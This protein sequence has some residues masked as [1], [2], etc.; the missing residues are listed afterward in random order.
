M[1]KLVLW[2][3]GERFFQRRFS[4]LQL[5]D[6]KID[7]AEIGKRIKVIGHLRQDF[8]IL[9]FG[10]PIFA[11]AKAFFCGASDALQII[12]HVRFSLISWLGIVGVSHW[13]WH[14]VVRRRFL[15]WTGSPDFGRLC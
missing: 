13:L 5:A 8:L 2:R 15:C 12:R 9:L 14:T 10:C 6:T 1:R 11:K 7:R 3:N 4:Q